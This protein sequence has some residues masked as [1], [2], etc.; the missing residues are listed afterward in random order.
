M[1]L[2]VLSFTL[3][4]LGYGEICSRG[5][6]RIVHDHVHRGAHL[7]TPTLHLGH[8]PCRSVG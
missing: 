1:A 6:T 2:H 7:R 3:I 8:E 5:G 4:C